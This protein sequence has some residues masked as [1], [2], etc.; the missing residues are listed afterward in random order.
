MH[1]FGRNIIAIVRL[2][3]SLTSCDSRAKQAYINYCD[4]FGIS[5]DNRHRG[6]L[7]KQPSLVI[8]L[9]ITQ[10]LHRATMETW[11]GRWNRAQ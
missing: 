2:S 11:R 7:S 9:S 1:N 5:T 4:A 10:T 3:K 8:G 6:P